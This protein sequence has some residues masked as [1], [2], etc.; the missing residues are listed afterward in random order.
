MH[1]LNGFLLSFAVRSPPPHVAYRTALRAASENLGRRSCMVVR[2][3]ISCNH[4]QIKYTEGLQTSQ[5]RV[6]GSP[7]QQKEN[8]RM[9]RCP[10]DEEEEEG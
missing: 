6:A 1:A 7:E 9:R 8:R 4:S 2:V 3:G 5:I 10:E